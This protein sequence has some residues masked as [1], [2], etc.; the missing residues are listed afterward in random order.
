LRSLGG[1]NPALKTYEYEPRGDKGE[2]RKKLG[3]KGPADLKGGGIFPRDV[4]LDAIAEGWKRLHG[5]RKVT[6]CVT[7][8]SPRCQEKTAN[9][10]RK[11]SPSS[12]GKKKKGWGRWG[13]RVGGR[14]RNIRKGLWGSWGGRKGVGCSG[15]CR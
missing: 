11:K 14:R 9:V 4:A 2:K 8:E 15:W 3:G 1:V 7:V 5:G 6:G 13:G 12:K 10:E